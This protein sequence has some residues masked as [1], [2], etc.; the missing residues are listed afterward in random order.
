MPTKGIVDTAMLDG[1][2]ATAD[3]YRSNDLS[4]HWKE[5]LALAEK[6]IL[7]TNT[8]G[9]KGFQNVAKFQQSWF[10]IKMGNIAEGTTIIKKLAEQ[11]HKENKPLDEAVAWG[12]LGDY[13]DDGLGGNTIERLACFSKAEL[14][15][16]SRG[17]QKDAIIMLKNKADVYLVSGQIDTAN[18]ILLSV[19]DRYKAIS[20]KNLHYTYD[21]LSA[22][23]RI[24]GDINKQ[25]YYQLE[26]IKSMEAAKDFEYA[27]DFYG[28]IA[29]LY[30]KLNKNTLAEVYFKKSLAA[31]TS[32][33]YDYHFANEVALYSQCLM[34]QNKNKEAL[35]LL[36]TS[37]MKTPPSGFNRIQILSAYGRYY[38][39]TGQAYTG[40][41]YFKKA[42]QVAD[43]SLDNKL[44]RYEGYFLFMTKTC[45]V[46]IDLKKFQLAERYLKKLTTGQNNLLDPVDIKNYEYE[47]FV[48]DSASRNYQSALVHFQKQISIR[49]S[50]FNIDKTRKIDSM[51]YAFESRQKDIDLADKSKNIFALTA[52]SDLQKVKIKQTK[53]IQTSIIFGTAVL[54]LVSLLLYRR[55]KIQVRSNRLLQKQRVEI[56]SQNVSLQSLNTKQQALLTEKEWLVKEI[57]HR[58][59]NNLQV[60][61]SLLSSHTIY[62]K[63]QAA[64]DAVAESQHRIQA[65]SLIHQKLY[66]RGNITDV[67]M[68]EYV[69]DLVDYLT[70]SFET[71]KNVI[72]K[73]QIDKIRLD[74]ASAVPVGLILNE[75]I[76]NAFKHAFPFKEN[77]LLSIQLTQEKEVIIL[78]IIDNGK[79][80]PKNFNAEFNNSFGMTLIKGMAEDL[81]GS[82]Q[83]EDKNGIHAKLVFV[84]SAFKQVTEP[85]A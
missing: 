38:L 6:V 76:T 30:L 48:L 13:L 32:R 7:L 2:L 40:L 14:I 66:N 77:D 78:K 55:Y 16:Q 70:D 44:I 67:Y 82:I 54:L 20:F 72:I 68:P 26:G 80:F 37:K 75:L 73:L 49:D 62:L 39:N 34:N 56:S 83:I 17:R 74:V 35:Q 24:R 28:R 23:A 63:E 59:K 61:K 18:K 36:K 3:K 5:G 57:H 47:R 45:Q 51:Q 85:T 1:L 22:I 8:P 46:F 41:Q 9:L 11:Y 65:M 27:I 12:N 21:L 4:T 25:V 10:L 69:G 42:A 50:L 53:T 33:Y 43:S 60:V 84:N 81:E 71:S 19:L 15:Y 31:K 29:H 64:I 52:I 79:G 58:V